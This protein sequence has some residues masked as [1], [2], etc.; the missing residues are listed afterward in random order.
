MNYISILITSGLTTGQL[1]LPQLLKQQLVQLE[2]QNNNNHQQMSQEA[3]AAQITPP[4]F[5]Q[6]N[7]MYSDTAP[8]LVLTKEEILEKT[9]EKLASTCFSKSQAVKMKMRK[10]NYSNFS[11]GKTKSLKLVMR[12]SRSEEGS[13]FKLLFTSSR[14]KNISPRRNNKLYSQMILR[15]RFRYEETGGFVRLNNAIS[16]T[17]NRNFLPTLHFGHRG[18]SVK[19]LQ[20]LLIYNGYAISVDGIFGALTETAVKAFQNQHDLGVDGVVGNKTWRA[21]SQ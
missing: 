13:P 6:S 9:R 20:R 2:K 18:I 15:H 19:V 7:K 8:K 17:A 3:S 11:C 16:T 1:P 10:I 4:E 12:V 14:L 5:M 21:L